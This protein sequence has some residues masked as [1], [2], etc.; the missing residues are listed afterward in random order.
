[1]ARDARFWIFC[2]CGLVA[3]LAQAQAP[4][5][6]I[7]GRRFVD[8]AGR[9][10]VLRGVNLAGDS[11][12]PPFIPLENPADLDPLPALGFNVVRLVISWEAFEPKPG[13]YNLDYL[14]RMRGIAAECGARGLY[15]I[16]DIHQDGY[17][18]Y[19]SRG[20]GDGFPAWA[21]SPR[22]IM[23][24]PDN[25]PRCA[26]WPIRMALD[27]GMHRSFH[28]FYSDRHGVRTKYLEMVRLLA[29][30]F[31]NL[32]M[33]IGYDLIN[34]P[35]GHEKRELAPLY[36]DAAVAIRGE[37][38]D[39]ILFVE[40]HVSTNTGLQTRLTRPS[41]TN[42]AYAPHYYK[43]TTVLFAS[44]R[45]S[46]GPINRAFAHIESNAAG[47][48]TPVFVGEFGAPADASRGG[49]YVSYLYDRLD[50]TFASGAQWN[51]TPHW[52]PEKRDGWNGEDFNII[53]PK[54]GE[55]LPNF[56]LRP[57]PRAIAG[58]PCQFRYQ[59]SH[60]ERAATVSI[61]YEADPARGCSEI[62]VPLKVFPLGSRLDVDPPDTITRYDPITQVLTIQTN[63]T[64]RVEC[65]LIAPK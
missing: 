56:R 57:F 65:R 6:R 53:C 51:Y 25:S 30:E 48:N 2:L 18:R 33:V 26:D 21:V 62:F 4:H 1:M 28:D 32:P 50:D 24:A 13:V 47:W 5:L 61:S 54:T 9:V 35:W 59:E 49:D 44:W 46:T 11:K 58:R 60:H 14:N 16:I 42:F 7:E 43:P 37:H 34:E 29:R 10:I 41:F 52:T 15:V 38:P 12:V 22:A 31:S 40:G 23:H 39:A 3:G 55:L 27:P 63:R 8:S 36:E 17:S 64:G 45:G 20:S 19:L